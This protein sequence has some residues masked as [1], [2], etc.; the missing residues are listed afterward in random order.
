MTKQTQSPTRTSGRAPSSLDEDL[1]SLLSEKNA[2]GL[3]FDRRGNEIGKGGRPLA[4]AAGVSELIVKTWRSLEPVAKSPDVDQPALAITARFRTNRWDSPALRARLKDVIGGFLSGHEPL[5]GVDTQFQLNW[6]RLETPNSVDRAF[7]L[8]KASRGMAKRR[9]APAP[10]KER[11]PAGGALAAIAQ[12][13]AIETE[14]D[15]LKQPYRKRLQKVLDQLADQSLASVELNAQVVRQINGLRT[16]LGLGL[17]LKE[18]G[19]PV[20]LRCVVAPRSKAAT[21]QAV[22]ADQKRKNLAASGSY[23]ALEIFPSEA[24]S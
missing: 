11:E 15:R 2:V 7:R 20:Y 9:P 24:D 13:R 19:E 6:Y 4:L 3:L 21:I 18:T 8:V 23:P 16:A 5:P 12:L 14:L 22:T 10:D 1:K 17:R